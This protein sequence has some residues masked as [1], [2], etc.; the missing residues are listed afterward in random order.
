MHCGKQKFK[1]LGGD[2][3][4]NVKGVL[5]C[6]GSIPCTLFWPHTV[7]FIL[8]L[9]PFKATPLNHGC[10]L[11]IT[12][13]LQIR[14]TAGYQIQPPYCLSATV[15]AMI[16]SMRMKWFKRSSHPETCAYLAYTLLVTWVSLLLAQYGP[17][18]GLQESWYLLSWFWDQ[19]YPDKS[20]VFMEYSLKCGLLYYL[21]VLL[22]F[23]W[24]CQELNLGQP[25]QCA[26]SAS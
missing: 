16:Q 21:K 10:H 4:N 5:S 18:L 24:K 12:V 8:P 19:A 7:S 13:P 20:R 23:S 14:G 6:L 1:L 2:L 3:S 9:C 25:T 22:S 26:M 11:V 17:E 15:L